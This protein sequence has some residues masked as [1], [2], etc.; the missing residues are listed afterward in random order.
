MDPATSIGMVSGIL[1]FVTFAWKLVKGGTEIYRQGILAENA[2]LEDVL[3]RVEAFHVRLQHTPSGQGASSSMDVLL[4]NLAKDCQTVSGDLIRLLGSMKRP[5]TQG[6]QAKWKLM[7]ASWNNVIHAKERTEL[8]EKLGRCETRLSAVLIYSSS[9]S[10]SDLGHAAEKNSTILVQLLTNVDELKRELQTQNGERSWMDGR[11]RKAIETLIGRQEGVIHK[12]AHS[13]ILRAL[14]YQNMRDRDDSLQEHLDNIQQQLR[15]VGGSYSWLCGPEIDS[16]PE[17]AEEAAMMKDARDKLRQWLSSDG[18]IFHIAGKFGSGK[19]TLMQLLR[20]HLEITNQLERWAGQRTLVKPA[21]FFSVMV[22][23][24]QQQ[25]SGLF[26]TLLHDILKECPELAPEVLPEIWR[27]ALDQPW[28]ASGTHLTISPS[29][30]EAALRKI[31]CDERFSTQ[32]CFC[33]FIDALDEYQDSG[34]RDQTDLVGLLHEWALETSG[35]VKLCVASREEP[36]FYNK[37]PVNATLR[38]HELTRF[39]MRR[40]VMQ[41]LPKIPKDVRNSIVEEIPQKAEGI[42]LWA[43]LVI[44]EIREDWESTGEVDIHV[45]DKFPAGFRPLVDRIVASIPERHQ[46]KAYLTFLMVTFSKRRNIRL[47]APQYSFLE[48]YCRDPSFAHRMAIVNWQDFVRKKAIILSRIGQRK[49]QACKYL[50]LWCKGLMETHQTREEHYSDTEDP[51]ILRMRWFAISPKINFTHRSILEYFRDPLIEKRLMDTVGF[52]S[53]TEVIDA[54]CQ[55]LLAELSFGS[56][57]SFGRPRFMNLLLTLRQSG[58]MDAP[59]Y[60][61]LERLEVV[62]EQTQLPF[63]LETD[64]RESGCRDEDHKIRWLDGWDTYLYESVISPLSVTF[65]DSPTHHHYSL[66]TLENSPRPWLLNSATALLLTWGYLDQP[67]TSPHLSKTGTEL[68][69]KMCT[70]LWPYLDRKSD[71]QAKY[72]TRLNRVGGRRPGSSSCILGPEGMVVWHHFP[73]MELSA[74]LWLGRDEWVKTNAGVFG[75]VM[76]IFLRLGANLDCSFEADVPPGPPDRD[77]YSSSFRVYVV[78]I[79]GDGKKVEEGECK[80]EYVISPTTPYSLESPE[81]L[82]FYKP[83]RL[84]E[85]TLREWI[86]WLDVPNKST[87]LQL[88]NERPASNVSCVADSTSNDQPTGTPEN[89][90]SRLLE[91]SGAELDRSAEEPKASAVDPPAARDNVSQPGSGGGNTPDGGVEEYGGEMEKSDEEGSQAETQEKDQG[92]SRETP[93]KE[94][95]LGEEDQRASDAST[96]N[97]EQTGVEKL[98]YGF[99]ETLR[100]VA[101]GR[102]MVGYLLTFVMGSI[103]AMLVSYVF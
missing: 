21:Y 4:S 74:L 58:G 73:L 87:L 69:Q 25:L 52:S 45:L 100:R 26:K 79:S 97:T 55:T 40:F 16:L 95:V 44:Q 46:R 28:Q 61:F 83:G 103:F 98:G 68:F 32:Y 36:A 33:I 60:D 76:E 22:G 8:E 96:A 75:Q 50:R 39:D 10:I 77:V 66:W 90:T 13:R 38:L 27:T 9:V 18:G 14:R 70:K 93:H 63:L 17:D 12:V 41:R 101:V 59:P 51:Q 81:K 56:A 88:L 43:A 5:D 19:S 82:P 23:G 3:H 64:G 48:E 72:R 62:F 2:T 37:F 86:E 54:I 57:F 102:D 20:N 49:N 84:L 15:T 94:E 67:R 53:L 7:V 34:G 31:I 30:V 80:V 91:E 85:W 99:V 35:N 78:K 29:L 92:D 42:F 11:D 65:V 24:P 47:T 1:S 89:D 71:V 6:L